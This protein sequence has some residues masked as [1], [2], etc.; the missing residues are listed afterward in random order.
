MIL[1]ILQARTG[2]SRLPGKVLL[3]L[4][5]KPMLARQ[6]ERL[7]RAEQL[8]M[9]IVATTDEGADDE[10]ADIAGECSVPV[11]RGSRDDVLDRFYQAARGFAPSHV[12][13]LT[14]DC[15]LCDWTLIDRLIAFALAGDYDYASNCLEPTWPD[16][17]DAEVIRF[18]ALK[19]A[20]REATSPVDRE[21]V[22]QFVV[23][24]PQRFRAGSQRNDVDLSAMRWTVDELRDY[25]FIS[26]VYEELY[27]AHPAFK[28]NDVLKLLESRPELLEVNSGIGRNEGLLRSIQSQLKECPGD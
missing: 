8:D 6:I 22:T 10:I 19:T 16:G 23:R 26:R 15:P 5:G 13:R 18:A 25:D 14:A 12:V 17:L 21:H 11:Y 3:P 27:G 4:A 7:L 24:D 28:T 1:G 9:L 20:W 2:S